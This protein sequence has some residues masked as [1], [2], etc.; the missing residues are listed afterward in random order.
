MA[1]KAVPFRRFILTFLMF[2][3]SLEKIIDK[4][5][6]FE[7][8]AVEDDIAPILNELQ[9][10]L[11]E[12]L[13]TKLNDRRAI[14]PTEEAEKKWFEHF[15]IYEFATFSILRKQIEKDKRPE[16]FKWFED[17]LWIL[18]HRDTMSLVNIFLFN[19][20]S[21]ESISNIIS[22]KY[23]KKVGIEA[24]KRYR[25]VFWETNAITA[26][27]AL[28]FF[29][30]FQKDVLIIREMRSGS[31]AQLFHEGQ[32]S[33]TVHDG[34]DLGVIFHDSNYIKWKIGYKQ[35]EV[36]KPEDFMDKVMRDSYFKY[37]ESMNMTRSVEEESESGCNE[38]VGNFS[39]ER[40]RRRNVEEHKARSA[41]HWL[42]LYAKA[43][44][45]R[46]DEKNKSGDSGKD[47]FKKMSEIDMK[48][49]TE[50]LM[51][52]S[53]NKEVYDDIKDDM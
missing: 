47:F 26:K 18:G 11:P 19:D 9:N 45:Y 35:F 46:T 8:H 34:S 50:K 23:R 53:E 16:Y 37:Y 31:E 25:S 32:E 3:D 27:D 36:P 42:E 10:S 21:L 52:I 20:E 2:G 30:P 43:H 41:K 49:N 48:F 38:K 22:F 33:S 14:N 13:K 51:D 24:L 29:K 39:S 5:K 44:K 7:L 28:Y 12:N 40:V 6:Q 15:D 4:L 17:C 1:A